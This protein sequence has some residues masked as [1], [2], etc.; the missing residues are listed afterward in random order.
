M[1]MD[2]LQSAPAGT[3]V[4]A[5]TNGP[6]DGTSA[7]AAGDGT[8]ADAAVGTSTG[9]SAD[10]ARDLQL[11]SAK[12]LWE[13]WVKCV[14]LKDEI[15]DRN[16]KGRQG[17]R[18]ADDTARWNFIDRC[19]LPGLK[20]G[21]L[22][23]EYDQKMLFL[24]SQ[25]D[26]SLS[27]PHRQELALWAQQQQKRNLASQEEAVNPRFRQDTL[28]SY[29]TKVATEEQTTAMKKGRAK[30]A[31][32]FTF[33]DKKDKTL[34]HVQRTDPSYLRWLFGPENCFEDD[35]SPFTWE[36]DAHWR[37]FIECQRLCAEHDGQREF[38]VYPRQGQHPETVMMWKLAIRP[39][40]T[41]AFDDYVENAFGSDAERA[42]NAAKYEMLCAAKRATEESGFDEED[43]VGEAPVV[44]HRDVE[45][46]RV[47][48]ATMK[49][50]KRTCE[51][52]RNKRM[53][54]YTHWPSRIVRHPDPMKCWP[55]DPDAWYGEDI[56]FFDPSFFRLIDMKCLPCINHGYAHAASVQCRGESWR[57]PRLVKGAHRETC[58]IGRN[59]ICKMCETE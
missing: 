9:T 10:A 44:E 8:S 32:R 46:S 41:A 49:L 21:K 28:K 15:V 26:Q 51:D 27:K 40:L 42:A 24:G 36:F 35:E 56:D 16:H 29:L 39:E 58:I 17:R 47:S 50:F 22:P 6:A 5:P 23:S 4:G 20:R 55:F 43:R 18:A 38:R 7:D 48:A 25:R 12:E 57:K 37:L 3:N 45:L 33:G 53:D 59:D 30:L 52:L 31:Y 14:K 34:H 1:S 2:G 19:V 13:F 11:L 54:P